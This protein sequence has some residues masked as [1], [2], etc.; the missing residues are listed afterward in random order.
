MKLL[1][2]SLG[3]N[4]EIK[5]GCKPQAKT[6][7]SDLASSPLPVGTPLEHI[8]I[9]RCGGLSKYENTG[10]VVGRAQTPPAGLRCAY[11]FAVGCHPLFKHS[12]SNIEGHL[13]EFF[14][15]ESQQ[16]FLYWL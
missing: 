10:E 2:I 9:D 16:K 12:H 4:H 7:D 1:I 6:K 14:V 8:L 13:L 15:H 3:L 11:R 5:M